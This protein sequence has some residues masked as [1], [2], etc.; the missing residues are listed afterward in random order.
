MSL[1][2]A[3]DLADFGFIRFFS[4]LFW[5]IKNRNKACL[6]LAVILYY[7]SP[8]VQPRFPLAGIFAS[9]SSQLFSFF[10]STQTSTQFLA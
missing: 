10:L 7:C 2:L 1:G 8:Y 9:P 6:F 3:V 4:I 5:I